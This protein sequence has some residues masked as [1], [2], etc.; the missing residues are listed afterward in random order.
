MLTMRGVGPDG[1]GAKQR[2]WNATAL[3]QSWREQWA[4]M[5]T[6]G[7]SRWGSKRVSTTAAMTRRASAS[8]RSTRSVPPARAGSSA[9]RCRAADEHRAIA[10]NNGAKILANP[11][12]GLDALTRTQAT[13]TARDL[14]LF[15]HRHSDGKEQF[16]RVLAAM[17]GSDALSHW[18]AT[19][20][21]TSGS[22]RSRCA[23]PKKR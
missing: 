12:V 13:F 18:G 9:A 23:A 7:C 8:S 6:T 11:E 19:G 14:A 5:S 20:T 17:R 1:F 21:R 4:S 2:D 10:Q 15:A 16:D 3:L 22:P